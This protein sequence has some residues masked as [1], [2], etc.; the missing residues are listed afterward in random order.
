[1]NLQLNS[2]KEYPISGA[3]VVLF[4]ISELAK[5]LGRTTQ[6]V[7]KWE[8]NKVIPKAVFRDSSKRRLYSKEQIELI[9]VIADEEDIRQGFNLE[10]SN[11]TKRIF[12][13]WKTT[14]EKSLPK[15]LVEGK[16]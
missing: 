13:S 15:K 4:P 1:M 12:D 5:A 8:T 14:T 10:N 16:K 2:G 3:K 7:R 11:F 6:T 9:V